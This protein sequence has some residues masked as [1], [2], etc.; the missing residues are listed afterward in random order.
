MNTQHESDG[1]LIEGLARVVA[2]DRDQVWLAAEQPAACGSCATRSACGGGS[3]QA[4]ASWRVPRALGA[5]QAPLALGDTVHIGVDRS[6]LTRASLASYAMPLLTMLM[7]AGAL[8]GAGN[9][10][11]IVAALAGLLVGVAAASLLARRWRDSLV[12]VV[13]GRALPASGASC[14]TSRQAV[15]AGA[16]QRITIPAIQQRSQ[17]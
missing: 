2:V 8:Q 15:N 5:G 12:P 9:V 16:L 6:A 4:A 10:V 14:A 17:R 1:A 13:L 7:A 11:A 3:S